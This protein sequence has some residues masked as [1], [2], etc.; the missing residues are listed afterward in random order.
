M[1]LKPQYFQVFWLFLSKA[2]W[3][4]EGEVKIKREILF[5]FTAGVKNSANMTV[6]ALFSCALTAY[7][8]ALALFTVT[9]AKDPVRVI[10]LILR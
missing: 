3:L 1:L 6:M 10:I 4:K 9:I 5:K 2:S 8:P 7:S